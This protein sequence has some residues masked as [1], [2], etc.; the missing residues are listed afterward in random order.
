MIKCCDSSTLSLY[1][2]ESSTKHTNREQ[3][4]KRT[5]LS[6]TLLVQHARII[7]SVNRPNERC[8]FLFILFYFL[9]LFFPLSRCHFTVTRRHSIHS[10]SHV[11]S[12]N[13]HS[14]V[15]RTVT[16]GF[17]S[18]SHDTQGRRDTR[19]ELFSFA[20]TTSHRYYTTLHSANRTALTHGTRLGHCC[21]RAQRQR[22][23]QT[24]DQCTHSRRVGCTSLFTRLGHTAS[25][26]IIITA[27]R[28]RPAPTT[29]AQSVRYLRIVE[30]SRRQQHTHISSSDSSRPRS[31]ATIIVDRHPL[32]FH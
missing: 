6:C 1:T 14:I 7:N 4:N 17:G 31:V 5:L 11:N 24:H 19:T 30:C 27:R 16:I 12:F 15:T 26:R 9:P 23:Q 8:Y 32:Q 20:H 28:T 25:L 13:H 22:G 2:N 3:Y 10:R 29:R 18:T 21:T